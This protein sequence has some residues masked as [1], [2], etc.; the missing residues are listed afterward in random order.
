MPFGNGKHILRRTH[1]TID[2]IDV[3]DVKEESLRRRSGDL[4]FNYSPRIMNEKQKARRQA[5]KR[6]QR[7]IRNNRWEKSG[8]NRENLGTYPEYSKQADILESVRKQLESFVPAWVNG[9]D[10]IRVLHPH[11]VGLNCQ[12][13]GCLDC[14]PNC[15]TNEKTDCES[16][17]RVDSVECIAQVNPED[18]WVPLPEVETSQSVGI[19]GRVLNW[20]V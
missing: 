18:E 13:N 6:R 16:V 3:S 2:T 8:M 4:Q 1:L 10:E 12:Y 15:E 17:E 11:E 9:D 20:F 19:I 7:K 14:E 5:E